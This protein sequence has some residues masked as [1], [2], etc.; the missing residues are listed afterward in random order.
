VINAEI[1]NYVE[2]NNTLKEESRVYEEIKMAHSRRRE[3]VRNETQGR[4]QHYLEAVNKVEESV[5]ESSTS[6]LILGKKVK[7]R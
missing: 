7:I 4:L 2:D 1:D 3:S 5:K 6:V